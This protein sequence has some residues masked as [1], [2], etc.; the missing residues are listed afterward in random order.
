MP[1]P[2]HPLL[3]L[4]V[5]GLAAGE[6]EASQTS[7][8][9]IPLLQEGGHEA[10]PAVAVFSEIR[11]MGRNLDEVWTPPGRA[12]GR[13]AAAGNHNS[14]LLGRLGAEAAEQMGKLGATVS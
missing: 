13:W 6:E 9:I 12:A 7:Q 2:R 3:I 1:R 8:E 11:I 4:F 10:S 5:I 14:N